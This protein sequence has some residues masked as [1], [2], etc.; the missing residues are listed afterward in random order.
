M[1]IP[2]NKTTGILDRD[3]NKKIG[4]RTPFQNSDDGYFDYT[5]LTKDA[6]KE[7]II[8][9][10]K[11]RKGERLMQPHLGLGLEKILFENITE[12][13]KI[14]IEDDIRGAMK[15][16]LP[17]VIVKNIQVTESKSHTGLENTVEIGI[18]FSMS[19]TPNMNDSVQIVIE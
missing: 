13:L 2:I 6:V 19:Y 12:E 14:I 10:I 11:T 5:S 17:F 7:N 18:D 3:S 16:W 15:R 1:A 9:L 4:I 8:S